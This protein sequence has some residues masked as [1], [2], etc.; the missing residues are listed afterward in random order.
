MAQLSSRGVNAAALLDACALAPDALHGPDARVEMSQLLQAWRVAARLSGDQ[1]F[2]VHF[3]A[4]VPVGAFPVIDFVTRACASV[5]E[6]LQ[7]LVDYQCILVDADHMT[8][9]RVDDGVRLSLS[10]AGDDVRQP[11]E[12][13]LAVFVERA[14]AFCGHRIVPQRVTFR[15]AAPK[16]TAPHRALFGI[17]PTFDAPETTLDIS[18]EDAAR[19]LLGADPALRELLERHARCSSP[20]CRPIARR[21]VSG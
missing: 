15:H 14:R 8:L 17:E 1:A 4:A 3:G 5:E 11:S 2:G 7:R 12:A 10:L 19:P 6:G 13:A 20:R 16:D 21:F 18:S 9:A